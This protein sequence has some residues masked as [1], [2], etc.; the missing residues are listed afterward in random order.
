MNYKNLSILGLTAL[1][2][3]YS[4]DTVAKEA[5][6]QCESEYM[7]LTS[8]NKI[9]LVGNSFS[10]LEGPTWSAQSNAFY[11]SDMDFNGSQTQGPG[12]TIYKLDLPDRISVYKENMGTNGLMAV[13]ESIYTMNHATRSLSR[14]SISTKQC[15]IIVNRFQGLQFNSP[16]DLV[17]S[18]SG[19]IYFTDPDWQLSGR[20]QETPFTGVYA[21]SP[22][23][24]LTLIDRS[25]V[26]PNG[27]ALSPDQQTLYVGSFANE[28][29]RYRLD[30]K[31]NFRGKE[32]FINIDSPDGIAVDCIGNLY[33][34]SHNEGAIYVYSNTGEQ[35]DKVSI[36]P[37]ITNIA[38]GG[39][40][41]K[42][43]LIT[44]DHGLY[45]M[46][47]NISGHKATLSKN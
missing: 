30:K 42:T 26:R 44:T 38:F 37:K 22:E 17:Q 19:V 21:Y 6:Y 14:L 3:F 2:Y 46:E 47:L 9:R 10:F 5:E 35:L 40:K 28:I 18:N 12:S 15:E 33:A 1:F 16:N 27:I 4:I 31:G 8:Q 43:L 32:K 23:G 13:G 7:P 24:V 34:T 25:L 45:T 11:F 20:K 41:L 29:V 39:E 36:G